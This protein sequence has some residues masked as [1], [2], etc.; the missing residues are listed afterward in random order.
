MQVNVHS[1][2]C[3]QWW[4][5]TMC[6]WFTKWAFHCAQLH[7]QGCL[8]IDPQAEEELSGQKNKQQEHVCRS[9]VSPPLVRSVS[10]W[11]VFIQRG[12]ST[13]VLQVSQQHG[14]QP[15]WWSKEKEFF[16]LMDNTWQQTWKQVP[17]MWIVLP[18]KNGL[19]C[20]KNDTFKFEWEGKNVA[21]TLGVLLQRTH[22]PKH[23]RHD[24]SPKVKPKHLAWHE[25]NT[26]FFT[27]RCL[28]S[29]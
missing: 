15:W 17:Q 5:L 23:R 7:N 19:K 4:W 29:F 22:N 21:L 16:R 24:S 25:S 14:L 27:Q 1:V 26:F 11:S 13:A 28:L 8:S 12:S 6:I 20:L 2:W 9:D 18:Q 10:M 3:C